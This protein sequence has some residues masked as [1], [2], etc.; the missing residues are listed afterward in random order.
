MDFTLEYQVSRSPILGV[1]LFVCDD[2]ACAQREGFADPPGWIGRPAFLNCSEDRCWAF[3]GRVG[4]GRYHQ[5]VITFAD[6]A[7]RSNVFSKIAYGAQYRVTVEEDGLLV[8]EVRPHSA[9]DYFS[10]LQSLLFAPAMALTVATEAAV[11]RICSRR[12]E[13]R[14]RSAV[15][16]NLLSFPVV[17]LILPFL[18]TS[19]AVLFVLVEV[20]AITFEAAFLLVANRSKRLALRQSLLVS[21]LMN[22]A[23]VLSGVAAIAIV[24]LAFGVLDRLG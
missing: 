16:A 22:T 20:F 7:R 12:V 5:L 15:F 8:R 19:S 6:G 18:Q 3:P 4:F 9:L 2:P 1:Q 21:V 11:A 13:V 24:V 14:V 10:P 17:W 23:S